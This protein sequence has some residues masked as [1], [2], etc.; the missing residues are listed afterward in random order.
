MYY[1]QNVLQDL[2]TK[3]G[4][5]FGEGGRVGGEEGREEE[6]EEGGEEREKKESEGMD[7]S[8][9]RRGGRGGKGREGSAGETIQ[10]QTIAAL[11]FSFS[12]ILKHLPVFS[13]TVLYLIHN[14]SVF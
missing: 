7:G 11:T 1:F 3:F 14:P 6:E 5:I 4:I 13:A 10:P 12:F 2:V 8:G 9:G